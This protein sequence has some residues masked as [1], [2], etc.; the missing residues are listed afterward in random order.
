[1]VD[2]DGKF[3]MPVDSDLEHLFAGLVDEVVWPVDDE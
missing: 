1:M 3:I 2:V